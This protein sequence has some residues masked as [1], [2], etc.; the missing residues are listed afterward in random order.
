MEFIYYSKWR[1][2]G[3]KFEGYGSRVR[4]KDL[5]ND[6]GIKMLTWFLRDDFEGDTIDEFY[7]RMKWYFESMED[8]AASIVNFAIGTIAA[9]KNN[10]KSVFLPKSK[11]SD[12][13]LINR[14]VNTFGSLGKDDFQNE[15]GNLHCKEFTFDREWFFVEFKKVSKLLGMFNFYNKGEN[16]WNRNRF[17][18]VMEVKPGGK[19]HTLYNKKKVLEALSECTNNVRTVYVYN[20]NANNDSKITI[21]QQPMN[22]FGVTTL[23]I[24]DMIKKDMEFIECKVCNKA[25]PRSKGGTPICRTCQIAISQRKRN[26]VADI[27]EYNQTN[28]EIEKRRRKSSLKEIQAIREEIEKRKPVVRKCIE[29]EMNVNEI[30]K[31]DRTISNKEIMYACIMRNMSDDKIIKLLHTKKSKIKDVK[32]EIKNMRE[33][34]K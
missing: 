17:K 23:Q 3:G 33:N 32:E 21:T 22:I 34:N 1:E 2:N 24:L 27:L 10:D 30:R 19:T 13:E 7:N 5:L 28:E 6:S 29:N 4:T 8:I 12:D 18:G 26:I 31:I 16:I 14:L 20:E 15:N 11:I 25:E 9:F